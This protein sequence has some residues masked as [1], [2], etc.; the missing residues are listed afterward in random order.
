MNNENNKMQVDIENLFKQNVN[1]LSAI[2]E[3]YRKLKEVDEKILQIKYIDSTLANK[4]KKEYEKLKRIILDENVQAKLSNDIETINEKLTNDIETTNLN[5]ETINEKLTNDI[6]TTNLKLTNNIETI[7]SQMRTKANQSDID[8]INS[9]SIIFVS[10]GSDDTARLQELINNNSSKKISL[11][12]QFTLTSNITLK[13]GNELT[14]NVGAIINTSKMIIM[15]DSTRLSNLVVNATNSNDN[16]W[17]IQINGNYVTIDN[18]EIKG[19]TCIVA[20]NKYSYCNIKNNKITINQESGYGILLVSPYSYSIKSNTINNENVSCRGI[21]L[22]ISPQN[23]I[24]ENNVINGSNKC[25]LGITLFN[26]RAAKTVK[27]SNC[28]CN[29]IINNFIK[30]CTEEGIS[31]DFSLDSTYMNKENGFMYGKISANHFESSTNRTVLVVDDIA[32][33]YD[34]GSLIGYPILISNGSGIGQYSTISMNFKTNGGL[35]TKEPLFDSLKNGETNVLIGNFPVHN[36]IKGNTV[37]NCGRSGIILYG[38]SFFST[39]DNNNVINCGWTTDKSNTTYQWHGIGCI[40]VT[41]AGTPFDTLPKVFSSS[42][43]NKITNNNIVKCNVGIVVKDSTYSNTGSL[44]S[45]VGTTITNNNLVCN[46]VK[47]EIQG[48]E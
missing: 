9:N 33:L 13:N 8:K 14:S 28:E 21:S 25:I 15:Q 29:T 32:D 22:N 43:N 7:N 46:K 16:D 35:Y 42:F 41:Y 5:I 6:E 17:V 38:L 26:G 20:P 1:D 11:V 47:D 39:V 30:D 4:L 3:L 27:N 37:I 36:S 31:I 45:P 34:D 23:C 12:G 18:N 24:V 40:S 44:G 2:K 19:K 10:G 48:A